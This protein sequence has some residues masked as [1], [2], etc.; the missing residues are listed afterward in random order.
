MK[1]FV[2][3][4]LVTIFS[5]AS[6]KPLD[7]QGKNYNIKYLRPKRQLPDEVTLNKN[8]FDD[9][10]KNSRISRDTTDEDVV[11][12]IALHDLISSVEHTLIHTAQ[13]LAA[14][15]ITAAIA[16]SSDKNDSSNISHIQ[17]IVLPIT[18]PTPEPKTEELTTESDEGSAT[19]EVLIRDNRSNEENVSGHE[20]SDFESVEPIGKEGLGI[21]FPISLNPSANISRVVTNTEEEEDAPVTEETIQADPANITIIHTINATQ[22]IPSESDVLHLHQQ[23]ITFFSA[24]AG[25]FPNINAVKLEDLPSVSQS[26]AQSEDCSSE[27]N[28]DESE[29]S[30]SSSE[31][32]SSNDS[33]SG[34]KE[35]SKRK[36]CKASSVEPPKIIES[37]TA[38][39][40]AIQK[41]KT[42]E[43][44]EK[45]AEVAADPVILTQGI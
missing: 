44:K 32:D 6:S 2:V 34:E 28:S 23:Q 7:E 40:E 12:T 43:L 38:S 41:N 1:S 22:V 27:E 25:V 39:I 14:S 42:E 4:L 31:E 20:K 10:F 35:K 9:I 15:N 19:G 45:I 36:G 18:V 21:V 33:S 8:F 26:S 3:V 13:N 11:P 37:S 30:S 24:N 17:Q 5:L 16:E 29:D